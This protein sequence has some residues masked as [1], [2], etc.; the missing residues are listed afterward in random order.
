MIRIELTTGRDRGLA[1][2]AFTLLSAAAIMAL[3][4]HG[5]DSD[6]AGS[7]EEI[8]REKQT[9]E[10]LSHEGRVSYRPSERGDT[11]AV[12]PQPLAFGDMLRTLEL[13]R[14]T[15]RFED[16]SDFRMKELTRLEIHR[17]TGDTNAPELQ[18]DEGQIYVTSRGGPRSIPIRT[19]HA[20]GVPKGTEFLVTVDERAGRTEV[21]MFD[22]EV[23]LLDGSTNALIRSGYQATVLP[24]QG[25]QVRPILEAKNI[26]QWWLYYPGILDPEELALRAAEVARLAGSLAAYRQGDLLQALQNY[27][28]YP[29]PLEP[30]TDAERAYL[31]GLFL[32][33]GA[34]DRAEA[35]LAQAEPSQ[36]SVRA[37]RWMI[38]AVTNPAG[39]DELQSPAPILNAQ[40]AATAQT[41]SEWLALSYSYQATNN[42]PAALQAARAAVTNSP[43]FGFGWARVAELEF[44]FG[45]IRA[46][47]DATD[48]ALTLTP[49]NAQ[50]HALQG[51][52]YAAETRLPAALL[53][54]E[55]AIRLDPALA[56]G[57]LG[58]GL[59]RIRLGFPLTGRSDLQTAA[60]L[61]PN[62]SLL[63]SYAGK[64]FTDAGN[65]RLARKELA[66]AAKLDREDPTPWLYSALEKWRQNRNNEAIEDL[67]QS[68]RLNDN[69]AVYRSRLKLDE[70]LAVRRAS[71]AQIYQSAGLYEISL[72]EA[73]KSVSYDYA[74]HSAHLFLAES[75]NAQRDPARFN[76]RYEAPWFN[77]LLLANV[78]SPV[79]AGVLSQTIS[80][81][82]YSRLFTANRLSLFNS[83]E[84]RSDGQ[85]R[86]IASQSGLLGK[87]AYSL[88]FDYQHNDGV[89]PNNEL[90]RFEWYGQFKQQLS[91]Q[92]SLFVLLKC[93]DYSAGDNFQHYD[94]A[95]A[96]TNLHYTETQAPIAL[97]ALHREWQP[98]MHTSLMVGRLT[99]EVGQQSGAATFDFWTNN[100]PPGINWVR[101]QSFDTMNADSSFTAGIGELNQVF[102][103]DRQITILGGRFQAGQVQTST[104]LN[105]SSSP[106]V[107][108]YYGT[109]VYTGINDSFQRW[110][111]YGYHTHELWDGFRLTGGLAYESLNYPANFLFPPVTEEHT[112][113]NRL[114]PKAALQW[115]LH[116]RL[117]LRGMY[118]QS[119]GGLAYDTS[120]RLEPAQL[121]GFSQVFRSVISEAEV[122]S[123]VVPQ[124]EVGGLALDW[125]LP[126]QT[127]LGVLGQFI[128]SDAEQSIGIFRSDGDFPPPPRAT[129]SATTENLNYEERSLVVW[130][131]QLLGT[132]WSLGASY[133]LTDSQLNW[134]YPEIPADL[135]LN[136]N[137]TEQAL[138]HIV[139]ARLQYQDPSGFFAAADARWFWQHNQGYGGDTIY[140]TDRPDDSFT[141]LD[142]LVGWRFFRRRAEASVGILNVTGQD[143]RLNS[144]TPYSDL[145]RE[146]VWALRAK[147]EL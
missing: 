53:A 120:V 100:P 114:C 147:F 62:R 7:A 14:A 102:Q 81:Q 111:L 140:S 32:A 129:P 8:H 116:P 96:S 21:T 20:R 90:D 55:T 71:L 27:P 125:K 78:L 95:W 17:R 67:E 113:Q 107:A 1:T 5:A 69:R 11:P 99:S 29:A 136:P 19:P 56:N 68:I 48:R 49:A 84:V 38:K 10:M 126:T 128:K 75:F 18:L 145:P 98:G 61:E 51:F 41:A 39:V 123:V 122:G 42:L 87:F 112:S 70:D 76:L 105:D 93:M 15:V 60:I 110:S 16:W 30:A 65:A 103:T 59:C 3:S 144:L 43:N 132:G 58:R 119:L 91:S 47:R 134:F 135:P 46:A 2:F 82:E 50:A 33:V 26:V 22:G 139:Q 54:F 31:A 115:Q 25:I 121:A 6:A 66:Y 92:D 52:L 138:L 37:L 117:A 4:A 143:Y 13:S 133:R 83:T 97:A 131:N 86:E 89:R 45:R 109:P 118:A 72:S 142:L 35:L 36:P 64:A 40:P 108:E 124:Y 137:R 130:G 63:R 9:G 127:Y 85:I 94:P 73:A 24:G 79:G 74:N 44:S 141:Q 57:W 146:R 34:V 23:A 88:D 80:Q 28:D 101:M 106:F 104:L 77:E 12:V